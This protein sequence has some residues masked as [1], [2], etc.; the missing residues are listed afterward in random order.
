MWK[1]ILKIWTSNSLLEQAW[2][3]SIEM[4]KLSN[5]FFN[6]SVD[7]LRG[8]GI[9]KE[10][11]KLKRRDREINQFQVDVRKKILTYLY[12]HADGADVNS[13][14]ILLNMVV[15]IE[16]LGDYT[17]NILD[18][19]VNFKKGIHSEDISK[20]LN[21]IELQVRDR[22]NKTIEV[23]ETQD[24]TLGESLLETFR[25]DVSRASDKIVDDI[26]TGAQIY[27]G[28]DRTAAVALYAR[29]LKRIGSHLK[30]IAS[31]IVNPAD[32]IGFIG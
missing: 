16:R 11:L 30:N 23:V 20:D 19:A 13:G 1:T 32:L 6:Q 14:V 25:E 26:L 5:D 21:A 28:G 18:L 12:H 8:G 10:L 27:D 9:K 2:T 31:T 17:K 7:S 22:F 24:E 15:D 4:L 3:Q 29:Y